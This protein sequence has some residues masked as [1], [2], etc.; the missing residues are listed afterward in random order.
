M[1]DRS[2]RK[3]SLHRETLVPLQGDELGAVQGGTQ[4]SESVS[5]SGGQSNSISISTVSISY[6]RSV[7][8][9]GR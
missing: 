9:S 5:I 6:S 1:N 7:S 3:L 8:F 4:V 2:R